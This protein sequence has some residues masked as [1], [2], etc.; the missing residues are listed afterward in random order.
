[1]TDEPEAVKYV[2]HIL[3]YYKGWAKTSGEQKSIDI[4]I[5][6]IDALNERIRTAEEMADFYGDE[7]NW[8]DKLVSEPCGCCSYQQDAPAG[9]DKGQ[10]AREWMEGK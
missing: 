8:Q 9:Q 5:A 7:G 3:A 6:H 1:M 4:A 10:R 2:K